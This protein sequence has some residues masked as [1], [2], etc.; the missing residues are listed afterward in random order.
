MIKQENELASV[1]CDI[2]YDRLGEGEDIKKRE[3]EEE[4]QRKKKY[5]Q[6][7][8]RDNYKRLKVLETYEVLVCSVLVF[9]M[10]HINNLKVKDLRVI[11]RYHS[12]SENLKG[13]PKKLK[14][15]GAVKYIFIKDWV[16]LVQIWGSGMSVVTN[17]GV[18]EAG[19]EMGERSG[20]SV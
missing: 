10:D 7:E 6:K 3:M 2:E 11:I 16:G 14:L 4:D 1:L 20:F 5:E 12:G 9:S 19:E 13:I 18:H 8:M 17:E 15:V